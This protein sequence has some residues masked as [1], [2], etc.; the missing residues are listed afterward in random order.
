[1][2]R[3][4]WWLVSIVVV[5]LS[6]VPN[7][8]ETA[9]P[10][11]VGIVFGEIRPWLGNMKDGAIPDAIMEALAAANPAERFLFV[12][13]N[14]AENATT[15]IVFRIDFSSSRGARCDEGVTRGD[16][17]DTVLQFTRVDKDP[18]QT[19]WDDLRLATPGANLPCTP[20]ETKGEYLVLG[21][22]VGTFV[23]HFKCL[24]HAIAEMPKLT[25][26]NAAR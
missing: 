12:R 20:P 24:E 16:T 6:N 10:E 26:R 2:K 19:T 5:V 15:G 9:Q 7:F 1:M 11:P 21:G 3:I 18:R 17:S 22:E 14:P 4:Q 8:A 23:L 25:V 13:M